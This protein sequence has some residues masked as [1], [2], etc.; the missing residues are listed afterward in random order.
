MGQGHWHWHECVKQNWGY[1]HA[2]WITRLNASE[3]RPTWRVFSK[4]RHA[5]ISPLNTQQ[6]DFVH[7]LAHNIYMEQLYNLWTQ[8]DQNLLKHYNFYIDLSSIAVT[9]KV[10]QSHKNWS[11]SVKLNGENHHARFERSLLNSLWQNANMEVSA[12]RKCIPYPP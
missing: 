12:H 7:D 10:Y 3:K 1:H 6:Q 5:S 4:S 11:D 8:L 2:V 9:F